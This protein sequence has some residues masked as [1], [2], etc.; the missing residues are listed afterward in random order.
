MKVSYRLLA[1]ICVAL[2]FT[3]ASA[4]L[5]T[6]VTGV[7][8]MP[9]APVRAAT[10]ALRVQMVLSPTQ[11]TWVQNEIIP[12]FEQAN[13]V[14][15][16]LEPVDWSNRMQ[17]I[18]VQTAAG[19]PPDV[20]MNGAEHIYELIR[21]ELV[22]DITDRLANWPDRRDFI[23]GAF[24]SSTWGGR[25]YGVPLLAAPRMWWYNYD[26]FEEAGLDPKRPPEDWE[27]LLDVV[28]K[29]TRTRGKEVIQ[30]GYSVERL[31]RNDP[32]GNIQEFVPY[33]WQ[34]GGELIN[35]ELQL[36]FTSSAAM[37]ALRLML[38]LRNTVLP[39]GYTWRPTGNYAFYEKKAAIFLFSG[40]VGSE[41]ARK[42]PK[43][44]DRIGIFV[45]KNKE[46][47]TPVFSDWVAIHRQSQ[48]KELAWKFIQTLTAP[49]ALMKFD[50]QMGLPPPRYSTVAAMVKENPA[51]RFSYQALEFARRYPIFPEADRLT[52]VWA[53][54]YQKILKGEQS[55]ENAM[56][57]AA[58]QWNDVLEAYR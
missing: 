44:L 56:A 11:I 49:E 52:R 24:G 38:D 16:E 47:V 13:K 35:E 32:F 29:L 42:D 37:Q 7:P 43:Q 9:P 57:S 36:G 17:K 48:Q 10:P 28:R 54:S 8:G 39:A 5:A 58:E 3:F 21:A 19:L 34:A 25:N 31:T 15:V 53:A 55:P 30:Q 18:M 51:T 2:V 23:P 20:F 45:P 26:L 22:L 12:R 46:R 1:R 33:L 40:L 6:G 41:I 14:K 50:L 27:D 4:V